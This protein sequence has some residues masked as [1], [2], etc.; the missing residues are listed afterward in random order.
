MAHKYEDDTNY[1]VGETPQT[2]IPLRRMLIPI[3]DQVVFQAAATY[4]TRADGTRVGDGVTSCEWIWDVISA[5]NLSTLLGFLN[6][7]DSARLYISTDRRDGTYPNPRS[8]FDVYYAIM[9][10]PVVAGQEGVPIART[11]YAYQSVRV[12]FTNLIIQ[13][14]YL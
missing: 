7:Q 3:P 11:P 6:G 10:K 13:P 14:G 4:Y 12:R 8:A 9:W 2:L 5:A 1:Q